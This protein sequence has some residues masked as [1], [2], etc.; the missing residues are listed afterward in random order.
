MCDLFYVIQVG[1]QSIVRQLNALGPLCPVLFNKLSFSHLS[2]SRHQRSVRAFARAADADTAEARAAL[3]AAIGTGGDRGAGG[4]AMAMADTAGVL[5]GSGSGGVQVPTV[6]YADLKEGSQ[7]YVFPACGHVFGYHA[8]IRG[9]PCPLCRKRGPFVPVAFSFEP[10]ICSDIPTHVFN[11]CGHIASRATCLKWASTP[12]FSSRGV[13]NPDPQSM[14]TVC[15]YCTTQLRNTGSGLPFSKLTLQTE[16]NDEWPVLPA[17]PAPA[18][19]VVSDTLLEQIIC[20]SLLEQTSA[21]HLKI[22]PPSSKDAPDPTVGAAILAGARASKT[23]AKEG[24]TRAQ[25]MQHLLDSE[26]QDTELVETIRSQLQLFK[27]EQ[28]ALDQALDTAGLTHSSQPIPPPPSFELVDIAAA[29][30]GDHEPGTAPVRL[31]SA[32]PAANSSSANAAAAV[33]TAASSKVHHPLPF[34]AKRYK[35]FPKYIPQLSNDIVY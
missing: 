28:Q 21:H 14:V 20:D 8:S 32:S 7:P 1:A 31:S 9:R 35:S 6:D 23:H 5:P 29:P 26:P 10:L 25:L 15:P 3:A 34:T 11:P 30:T 19:P 13:L 16:A 4:V 27:Q 2:L 22:M 33:A 17:L 12:V 18:A 24:L